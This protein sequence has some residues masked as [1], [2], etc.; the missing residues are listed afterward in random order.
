ME[1]WDL[2]DKHRNLTGE[3]MV[4]GNP[5]PADRY[6]LVVHICIFNSKG[7]MLIQHRTDFKPTWSGMWD[8]TVGGAVSAGESS[9]VG[10]MREVEEELGLKLDLTDTAPAISVTFPDGFDDYY[11]VERDLD[12]GSL[13]FQAEEVQEAKWASMEEIFSMIDEGSFIPYH[14][15]FIEYLFSR[16]KGSGARTI[17]RQ[18]A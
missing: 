6:H 15:A 18:N 5:V 10:A 14:K 1:I 2:Y 4:R 8:L 11:I 17:G 7:E 13:R 9:V 12:I 3:T 16:R